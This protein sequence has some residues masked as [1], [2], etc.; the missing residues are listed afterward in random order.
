M[1]RPLSVCVLLSVIYVLAIL[2][3]RKRKEVV[4]VVSIIY[5]FSVVL[6]YVRWKVRKEL[7]IT[8]QPSRQL[9]GQISEPNLL[10]ERIWDGSIVVDGRVLSV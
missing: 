4:I 2:F 9:P 6:V 5:F 1:W 10:T 8:P 3:L 7:V